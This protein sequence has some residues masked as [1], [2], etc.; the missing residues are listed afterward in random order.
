M[1]GPGESL[2]QLDLARFSTGEIAEG[3]EAGLWRRRHESIAE[4]GL[5]LNRVVQGYFDCHA[6]PR[7]LTRLEGFR[8]E[9]CRAWRHAL[10]RRSQ[11]HWLACTPASP[12]PHPVLATGL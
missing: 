2:C 4:V 7:N 9:V 10:L 12:R 1:L 6:V 8:S 3:L 11:R 5:W